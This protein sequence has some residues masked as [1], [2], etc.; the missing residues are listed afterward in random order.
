MATCD[1][2]TLIDEAKC[3][4]CLVSHGERDLAKLALLVRVLK[5]LDPSFVLD[6]NSLMS[7]ANC[8]ECLMAGQRQLATL[9]LLCRISQA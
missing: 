3:F 1:T 5:Q 2:Q 8:F 4:E 6:I 7:E 9:A